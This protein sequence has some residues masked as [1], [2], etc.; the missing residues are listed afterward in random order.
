MDIGKGGNK[1]N[2][3]E[4]KGADFK[5]MEEAEVTHR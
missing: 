3:G 2:S 5:V 4:K 1:G